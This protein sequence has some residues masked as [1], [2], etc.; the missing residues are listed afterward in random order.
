MNLSIALKSY[1]R[2]KKNENIVE[3]LNLGS[4]L[5]WSS[6]SFNSD[7]TGDIIQ[8]NLDKPWDWFLVSS[9]L[10]ITWDV[11]QEFP[12]IM[13]D[14]NGVS[15]NPNITWDIIKENPGKPWNVNMFSM[16]KNV[17]ELS[18]KQI[19]KI[20]LEYFAKK[21]IARQWRE[22]MSNPAYKLC[23]N[24]LHREFQEL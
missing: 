10:N 19:A 24:R 16:N 11:I 3:I 18:D 6:I 7:I 5:D 13:W 17:F 20:A 9:N 15:Y 4:K 8:A 1:I 22:S 14:W 21:K 23:R 2:Q 12:G